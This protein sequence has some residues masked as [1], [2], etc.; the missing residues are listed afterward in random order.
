MISCNGEVAGLLILFAASIGWA[1]LTSCNAIPAPAVCANSS[2]SAPAIRERDDVLSAQRRAR[3]LGRALQSLCDE[4]GGWEGPQHSL[5]A[6]LHPEGSTG[7]VR[8]QPLDGLEHCVAAVR[9]E[10]AAIKHE[11]DSDLLCG[12]E[13]TQSFLVFLD[14]L[15]HGDNAPLHFG[16]HDLIP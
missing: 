11:C 15:H 13:H 14:L 8:P 7:P 4:R 5:A 1:V 10:F 9:K 3:D 2:L 12:G 6:P 16:T